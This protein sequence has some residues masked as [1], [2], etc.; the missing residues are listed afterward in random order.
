MGT[1]R[2]FFK[3][4]IVA[5]LFKCFYSV[6]L[7]NVKDIGVDSWTLRAVEIHTPF[8]KVYGILKVTTTSQSEL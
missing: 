3:I 4:P 6:D 7:L 8:R 1:C 2:P 5:V